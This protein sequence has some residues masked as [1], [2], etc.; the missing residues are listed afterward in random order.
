[1]SFTKMAARKR[2]D[3]D[4]TLRELGL[5]FN[6]LKEGDVRAGVKKWRKSELRF[7]LGAFQ[8]S[9]TASDPFPNLCDKAEQAAPEVAALVEACM[10]AE[11]WPLDE[12]PHPKEDEVDETK[13]MGDLEKENG[14]PNNMEAH[15][16]VDYGR[17]QQMIE[18]AMLKKGWIMI[19]KD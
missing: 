6:E 14:D 13:G 1:M 18:E 15:G 12:D 10:D 16:G 5:A 8:Q 2:T 9:V 4:R 19:G 3:P 11:A 17:I 7:F